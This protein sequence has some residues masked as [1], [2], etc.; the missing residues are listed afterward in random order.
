MI[1]RKIELRGVRVNNLKNIDLDIPHGQFLSVCGVSGSGKSSLAFETLFAEGQ[2]RYFESLSTYTRQFLEQLDKP[3]ADR[4]DNILPAIALRAN[5][6]HST[7]GI[8]RRRATVGEASEI[9]PLLAL[10]FSK[11]GSLVCPD[12]GLQVVAHDPGSVLR[13][14]SSLEAGARYQIGFSLPFPDPSSDRD[15]QLNIL[16]SA[17]FRRAVVDGSMKDLDLLNESVDDEILVIVDRLTVDDKRSDRAND[18]LETAFFHSTGS[19]ALL[20]DKIEPDH[21]IKNVAI[22]GR[23][24]SKVVFNKDRSCSKCHREFPVADP[25]LFSFVS[26][27][28]ACDACDGVG[29]ELDP[30]QN[31]AKIRCQ[32]C[33]GQRLNSDALAYRIKS[34]NLAE[35]LD[36]EIFE[37]IQFFRSIELGDFEKQVAKTVCSRVER[38]LAYLNDVGVGYV[39]LNRPVS[40]LSSGEA[41]RVMLTKILGSTLSSMLYV[42]DEPSSGLHASEK[43][44]LV[45]LVKSIAQRGNTVVVVDHDKNII[46]GADRVVEIGP[47]SGVEG[48]EITFDGAPNAIMDCEQS[49]T[50]Q[51][52]KHFGG[53]MNPEKKR[54]PIRRMLSLIGA[55]GNNLQNVDVEIPLGCLCAISG[56]SGAGKSSLIENTLLPAISTVKSEHQF[57]GLPYRKITGCEHFDEV[58]F[59]DQSPIGKSSRSNPV[60]Y[61]KAFDEIRKTFAETVDAKTRNFKAGHFSFN[62]D[63]GRCEK[64]HGAGQLTIDMQFMSDIHV[65]CDQCKGTRYSDAVLTVKYRAK[66][67]DEVLNMTAR[68]AFIFFRGQTRVQTRLKALI[69]VGL[70]YIRLGQPATTLSSGEAQRLKL[71]HYLNAPKSQRALFII[72]EPTFGLHMRDILKLV[73]CF[74][75]LL[76]AGH[77][78]LVIEH[79]LHLLKHADWIIDL[80]PGAAK[81][82]G[83]II[84][85]GTPEKICDTPTSITGKFLKQLLSA[86]REALQSVPLHTP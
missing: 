45:N 41:Q 60:T 68:E 29:L 11:I 49:V 38:R 35:L 37:T 80:G 59:V 26:Q 46:L 63:G 65:S 42:L 19:V 73:D 7:S 79:N 64:C 82:G 17:G 36:L 25:A 70:D 62:V 27:T 47:S 10:L 57:S 30:E 84:A 85:Q 28:G 69:D 32:K 74:D 2:R 12:C 56:V 66:N 51:F 40:T 31:N 52:L 14:V 61:I 1:Q 48:G 4:I 53:I 77:S 16:K 22:D 44:S 67:I 33:N 23:Q 75:T 58:V 6:S 9:L 83:R 24:W 21:N 54:R 71:A 3:D 5:R 34:L 15:E 76:S 18:S 78:M 13:F 8:D 55:T 81:D 72:N 20:I 86:E 43:K 39:S 50:G